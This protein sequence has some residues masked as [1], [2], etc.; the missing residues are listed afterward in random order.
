[1]VTGAALAQRLHALAGTAAPDPAAAVA[2]VA[3]RGDE[4]AVLC[5]GRT[6]RAGPPV[7]GHT[8]FE[9]GSVTKTFT[10]LLLAEMAARGEVRYDDPINAYLPTAPARITLRHLAT[11]TSGL[12]RQPRGFYRRALPVWHDNP[13]VNYT[14]ADLWRWLAG[15]RLRNRPGARVHYSNLGVGLLGHVLVSAAGVRYTDLLT[16]RVLAPLGMLDTTTDPDCDQATGYRRG[17]PRPPMQIPALPAAGALRST[18]Q[19]LQRY[20]RALLQP[21]TAPN[22]PLRRALSE[23]T[24]P[25]LTAAGSRDQLCLVWNLRTRKNHDLIFHS[26][27]TRGFTTF[28]GFS[29]Q[30]G[31]AL[32]AVTNSAPTT[33]CP[34]FIQDAYLLLRALAAGQDG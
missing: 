2:L 34:Q 3:A 23:V 25:L 27:A 19:D 33:R 16:T 5:L 7:T 9:L 1:M 26:G 24:R 20:L 6:D 29:P 30:T 15:T 18:A 32:A 8:R 12:P 28:I 14:T 13:Y 17:R 21:A 22:D 31:A 10:A 4:S 11:H